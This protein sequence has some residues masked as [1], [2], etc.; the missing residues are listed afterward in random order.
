MISL[1]TCIELANVVDNYD[2]RV[3]DRL[4]T[5][6]DLAHLANPNLGKFSK[7]DKI[8]ILLKELKYQRTP[9][10]LTDSFQLD[11]LQFMVDHFYRYEDEPG[12]NNYVSYDQN[13]GIVKYE[14]KFSHTY[15][16]L[17]N[18]L[19]L[20]GYTINART[21]KKMLPVEIEEARTEN[22]LFTLLNKHSFFTTKGHLEQAIQNHSQGN[23]AGANGQF[24]PFIESLLIDICRSLAPNNK[25]ENAHSAIT[26]LSKTVNPPFLRADLNEVEN[27]NCNKPF[28]EGFWKRLHPEGNH[29]GLSTKEDSTFR[30][31]ISIVVAHYLLT[32]FS[33]CNL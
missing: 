13:I 5:A 1:R 12:S 9:G 6:L 17:A 23:W 33:N 8:N 15:T 16:S 32:R 26:I 7:D 27:S 25:C 4:F 21:I 14:N 10:L 30:Y 20:D 19:M 18:S 31:H 3:V 28:I 11:V 24:R 2:S 29:P 22:E